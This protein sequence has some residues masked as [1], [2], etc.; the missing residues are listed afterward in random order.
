MQFYFL[1]DGYY[2]NLIVNVVIQS[3]VC[4]VLYY[5]T[6]KVFEERLL[7]TLSSLIWAL[8][9]LP[10]LQAMGPNTE[11]VYELFLI[12]FVYFLYMFYSR[13]DIKYLFLSSVLMVI[14][15][16]TRPISILYPAY[17]SVIHIFIRTGSHTRRLTHIAF[18][19]FIFSLGI[20]PW[21]YRGYKITGR[22]IPLVSYRLTS[23][24]H[25]QGDSRTFEENTAHPGFVNTFKKEIKNPLTFSKNA[26]RR[27]ARFWYYG[28]STPVRIVD[29]VFQFPILILTMV[30]IWFARREKI[31]IFSIVSTVIYFWVVYGATHAISRYS[32]PMIALLCPFVAVALER[33]L[34][35]GFKPF[36]SRLGNIVTRKNDSCT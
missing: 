2:V 27:L 5:L 29:A 16:L 13:K 21:M 19:L 10:M 1:G 8:Y 14:L 31:L 20:A 32:F 26:L 25:D 30:G 34:P 4:F 35:D 3:L 7:A 12:S 15:T 36:L 28:H 11:A 24:Q 6:I 23:A 9:P 18:M 33:I 17:F 22:V